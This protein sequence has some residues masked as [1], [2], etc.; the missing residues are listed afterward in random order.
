MLMIKGIHHPEGNVHCLYLYRSKGE[1]G[2]TG[3]EDMHKFKCTAL[4]NYVL[5][6]TDMPTPM[7]CK[8][9]TP[10]Q[11]C[12]LKFVSSLQFT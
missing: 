6:S 5:N 8:T 12:L 4:A 11:K 2:L 10:M 1:R 7:V 9:A 3:V